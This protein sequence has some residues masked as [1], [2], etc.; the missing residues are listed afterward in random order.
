MKRKN[1]TWLMTV[2]ASVVLVSLSGCASQTPLPSSSTSAGQVVEGF[3]GS[4]SQSI[5]EEPQPVPS[6]PEKP[7]SRFRS[8]RIPQV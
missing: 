1:Y 5:P 2:W 3:S 8:K 7:R 6:Q 4:A